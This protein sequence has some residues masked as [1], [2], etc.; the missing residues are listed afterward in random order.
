MIFSGSIR[1]FGSVIECGIDS[2]FGVDIKIGE[3][4]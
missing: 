1:C 2:L 4:S 3:G